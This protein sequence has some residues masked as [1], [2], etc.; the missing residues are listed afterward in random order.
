MAVF[1]TCNFSFAPHSHIAPTAPWVF[2]RDLCTNLFEIQ[3]SKSSRGLHGG[4]YFSDV[5]GWKSIPISVPGPCEVTESYRLLGFCLTY[6]FILSHTFTLDQCRVSRR[7]NSISPKTAK[8]DF[9]SVKFWI[10]FCAGLVSTFHQWQTTT[11]TL[12]LNGFQKDFL[13]Q[14]KMDLSSVRFWIYLCIYLIRCN[15]L[16]FIFSVVMKITHPCSIFTLIHN[17]HLNQN[18]LSC[19][20]LFTG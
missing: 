14:A 2:Q 20:S 15:L 3:L 17:I 1:T 12:Q 6:S 16:K 19:F 7:F 10:S 5:S 11:I 18:W 13:N 8:M 9:S 4:A